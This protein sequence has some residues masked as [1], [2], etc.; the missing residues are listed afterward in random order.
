VTPEAAFLICASNGPDQPINM[1]ED[2]LKNG[3][4]LIVRNPPQ[5]QHFFDLD[6]FSPLCGLR[7][8]CVRLPLLGRVS[9]VKRLGCV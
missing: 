9:T 8:L 2:H 5:T 6:I 3:I 7:G 1:G 4:K